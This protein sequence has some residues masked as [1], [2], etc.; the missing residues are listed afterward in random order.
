MGTFLETINGVLDMERSLRRQLQAAWDVARG[1]RELVPAS[2]RV[3]TPPAVLLAMCALACL[4][5]WHDFAILL[6]LCFE[7]MLRP[8]ELLN[9]DRSDIILP[10]ATLSIDR[11]AYIRYGVRKPEQAQGECSMSVW[12]G[13]R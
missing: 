4:W 2:N 9:L 8:G 13:P 3:P 6:L 10:S 5:E 1:W 7:A 12:R 11:V